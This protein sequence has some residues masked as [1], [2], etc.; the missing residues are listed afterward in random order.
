VVVRVSVENR[1]VLD[2][3]QIWEANVAAIFDSVHAHLSSHIELGPLVSGI[4]LHQLQARGGDLVEGLRSATESGEWN[5]VDALFT[6][7]AAGLASSG[8][9]VAAWLDATDIVRRQIMPAL[10]RAY[11]AEPERLQAALHAMQWMGDRALA[12]LTQQHMSGKER[13]LVAQR[14]KTEQ[15]RLRFD[16]LAEAG[17]LGVIVCDLL[18]NIKE[19]NEGFLAMIGYSREELLSGS[20][21]WGDMTPPEWRHLDDDAIEQLKVSG[22]TRPWEKEYLRKDGSRMPILVGVAMLDES[23][24]V[25]FILDITERKRMEEL[26]ERSA[27]LENENRRIQ[28][29]NRLKSEFL[30]NM[31]HELRTPLN[32]IIGFADVLHDGEVSPDSPEHRELLGE[33]L[34]S[35]RHLLKLLNDVL[36]LAKVES[37]TLDFF[38]EE[39]ELSRV[40]AEVCG[41]VRGIASGKSIGLES[42]IDPAVNGI[43]LDASRLKQVLYNYISNA[44]KFTPEGG[45]VTIRARSE[46]PDTF[47][48]EVI[49]T[50]IGIAPADVSRLFVEFQQ[51]DSGAAKKHAGTGLGLA[52]TKRIVEAQGGWVGV[53]SALGSGS[54]FFAVLPRRGAP[55]P[56]DMRP[57]PVEPEEDGIG[58]TLL[59]VDDD[60]R[61]QTILARVLRRHGFNVKV[62]A[63]GLEAVNECRDRVFGAITLD[64]LLPDITGLEVLRRLRGEGMN[65]DTPVVIVSVVAERGVVGGFQVHD[66]M[67]K[68]IDGAALVDSLQRAGLAPDLPGPILVV[69]DDGHAVKLMEMMLRRLGYRTE[70]RLDGTS[71]LAMAEREPP[72]A[73]IVDLLMPGMDGFEFLKRFRRLAGCEL[74]PAIVWTMK[75]LTAEDNARLH[76]LAQAVVAKGEP[77]SGGLVVQLAALLSRRPRPPV[78]P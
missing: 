20:I 15:A 23:E 66:Y 10:F 1:G 75:D 71:A 29:T 26:R 19:A 11:V 73:V 18:G 22:K 2:L 44:L 61:D 62:V 36:D 49:D 6:E 7:W 63:T 9:G 68:P 39:L 14:K 51:L 46:D 45:K 77:P 57:A 38:P 53:K 70:G 60:I 5:A 72:L 31:S 69:D 40:V 47:R 59:V 25:A 50:G 24:C 67:Q 54:V 17:V 3:W 65:R 37:G 30:A 43:S 32:C 58:P 55:G 52:L 28:E 76:R 8:I 4:P 48:L 74:S 41:V 56:G 33:I 78:A 34:G 16:R 42:E 21:R 27:E 64:L 13:L 12:A 35:G